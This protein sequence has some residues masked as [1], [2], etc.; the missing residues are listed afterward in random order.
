ML[1]DASW[2]V[3]LKTRGAD[4]FL[5]TSLCT[6]TKMLLCGG[7]MQPGLFWLYHPQV[8][9]SEILYWLMICVRQNPQNPHDMACLT[10]GKGSEKSSNLPKTT[11][12]T[13]CAQLGTLY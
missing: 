12:R 1:G 8:A 9:H 6:H 11:Q 4:Y 13:S 2:T 7:K 3:S 10:E 5:K